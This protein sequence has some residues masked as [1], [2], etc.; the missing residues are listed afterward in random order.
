MSKFKI[1]RAE[2]EDAS[3]L[4][5]FQLAMARESEGLELERSTVEKGVIRVFQ[6]P[7]PGF[8]LVVEDANS[9]VRACLLCLPEWSDWRNGDVWW[10]HSVFVEV[11]F[12]KQGL[13]KM[14]YEHLKNE[15]ATSSN[16]K[17]I[18]LYVDLRNERARH[19]YKKIGM[20][21]E[22]YQVF[23]WMK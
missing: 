21:G 8:Y 20:N 15:V 14:M 10:I 19:V 7:R 2:P 13:F 3:T 23:E 5:N 1:R 11:E 9:Q 4:V 16:L 6:D 17:G 18:R 12:R 22:H